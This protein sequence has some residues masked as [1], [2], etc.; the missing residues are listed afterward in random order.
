MHQSGT[1]DWR[2]SASRPRSGKPV[3]RPTRR[4]P[5]RRTPRNTPPGRSISLY[6]AIVEAAYAALHAELP[7]MDAD[8]ATRGCTRH[9]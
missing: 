8:R 4:P 5:A 3:T 7:R 1:R 2:E 9:L 6:S